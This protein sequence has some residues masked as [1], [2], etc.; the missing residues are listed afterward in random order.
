MGVSLLRRLT[1]PELQRTLQDL[2][3]LPTLPD[4]TSVPVDNDKDGF[5][6]FAEVQAMSAQHLLAYL[7]KAGELADALLAD[8]KR[9][10]AVVGC[11]TSDASCLS[12][13]VTRFGKLAYRRSLSTAEVEAVARRAQANALDGTDQLRYA[14]QA[15]LSSADFLYRVE[16]GDAPEGLSTLTPTELATRLSFALWGRGP[17]MLLLDDAEAGKLS[18]PA[19]LR[20]AAISML[21]DERARPLYAAFFRQW[22]GYD[23]LRAPQTRPAD[24]SDALLAEMQQ[25]TDAVLA[26]H[27]F[28][29]GAVLS[30]LT[31]NQT[32][33]TPSLAAFYGLPAPGP[34]GALT[35]PASHA[36]ANS[37]I[38]GHA[39]LLS[40]KS[41]G[42][43][44]ALRGNWLRRTFFCSSIEI[45]P[46]IAADLGDLLVGLTRVEVVKKRNSEATCKGCH[47][48][49]DPIG[50]GLSAFDAT[51]RLDPTVDIAQYGIEPAL[52]GVPSPQFDSLAALAEKLHSSPQVSTCLAEK[53]FVYM[54]GRAPA[55]DDRCTL[56]GA[57]QTFSAG[58]QG[59]RSLVSGLVESPAFRLRRAPAPDSQA[60]E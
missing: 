9:H 44:I 2:F 52:P 48:L 15:L 55:S 21:A 19:G 41:D 29:E 54:N 6:T 3:Q 25:E 7:D 18:T 4:L 33:V 10:A 57:E 26:K 40:L 37:G 50:V 22:L 35:I 13:F 53:L 12:S 49:I 36:R 5:K 60:E 46:E 51:G 42:D 20:S 27:A 16:L 24:W 8:S 32:T 38:L 1:N 45:P 39:S 34:D 11:E 17:S 14:I 59:F 43:K 30:A 23:T 28:G 58:G 31:T 56:D 47:G